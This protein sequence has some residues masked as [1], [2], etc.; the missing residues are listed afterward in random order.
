MVTFP[1]NLQPNWI[2]AGE[3]PM[4]PDIA[5]RFQ[6]GAD[7]NLRLSSIPVDGSIV[8]EWI[9]STKQFKDFMDFWD[10]VEL[11]SSFRLPVNFFPTACNPALVALLESHS[12][13]GL[14]RFAEKYKHEFLRTDCYRISATLRGA[15]L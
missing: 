6:G 9:A 13:T 8:C 15:I 10:T 3:A 11:S 2:D 14:W 1:R 12:P 7:S 4:R 5:Q